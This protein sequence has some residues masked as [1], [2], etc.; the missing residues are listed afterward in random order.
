MR[1][2][3][4]PRS[5]AVACVALM[6]LLPAAHSL[7]LNETPSSNYAVILQ[8]FKFQS[9]FYDD[10]AHAD[11]ALVH[12]GYSVERL[13]DTS[14]DAYAT[15]RLSDFLQTLASGPG[16]VAFSTHGN[17]GGIVVE[18]YGINYTSQMI[19]AYNAY[20]QSG[21]TPAEIEYAIDSEDGYCGIFL[22]ALGIQNH[23][24]GAQSIIYG[25][26]CVSM[27]LA[28]MWT[29][30][31][32][33]VGYPNTCS[34]LQ[35][36]SDFARFWSRLDGAEG[37]AKRAAG[38]ALASTSLAM[39]GNGATVLAPVVLA[40]SP[41]PQATVAC[42]DTGYVVFDTRMDTSADP[43]LAV[44]GVRHLRLDETT[45]IGGDMLRFILR[46]FE[47]DTVIARA[48]APGLRSGAC[49]AIHLDGNQTPSG[50]DGQGPA[51]DSFEWSALSTCD[52]PY[53][54]AWIDGVA[55]RN[56]AARWEAVSEEG[57]EAYRLAGAAGLTSD[58]W[59]PASEEIPAAGSGSVYT[60][61][62]TRAFP[63]YRIEEREARGA[64]RRWLAYPPFAAREAPSREPAPRPARGARPVRIIVPPRLADAAEAHRAA[65]ERLGLSTTVEVTE[66]SPH[67][68]L[69]RVEEGEAGG[70]RGDDGAA[71]RV[72]GASIS[73]GPST[74]VAP[75]AN[76]LAILYPAGLN[77]TGA[78]SAYAA[79]KAA[80]GWDV[81]TVSWPGTPALAAVVAA[82]DSL[83]AAG[84]DAILILG[85][86]RDGNGPGTTMPA[87]MEP[88][89]FTT[90]RDFSPRSET[91][92][93]L[94]DYEKDATDPSRVGPWVGYVPLESTSD[95]WSFAD[96]MA[97]YE[98][99]GPLR[100]NWDNYAAWG[101][102]IQNGWNP[103]QQVVA[104]IDSASA[105]VPAG[106]EKSFLWGSETQGE[107]TIAATASLN[108]G[109]GVVLALS[110]ASAADNPAHWLNGGSGLFDPWT[111]L[112]ANFKYPLFLA[113]S[114]LAGQIDAVDPEDLPVV[115]RD[116]IAV[117][118]RGIIALIGP[119]RGFY[120]DY[121]ARYARRFWEVYATGRHFFLG[122]IH[123]EVRNSLIA[124]SPTDPMTALF[125]RLTILVGDP[126]TTLP[127]V[128]MAGI[129][130][131]DESVAG[132]SALS[133]VWL[134]DPSP[135]PF[136]PRVE[137]RFGL[138]ARM[139]AGLRVIDV[140]GRTVATLVSGELPAG[141]HRATWHG[142]D[143][144]GRPVGSGVY[145]FELRAGGRRLVRRGALV[146]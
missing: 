106:W 83:E 112:T 3:V 84:A 53:P 78:V 114:C 23:F 92:L 97:D 60:L 140:S 47:R 18:T 95:A 127:G 108:A 68:A 5:L 133:G 120:E 43:D 109:Q 125:C 24:V 48:N 116:L 134:T 16:V 77:A 40:V 132:E 35:T 46:P 62:P 138:P 21:L 67:A 117:P 59:A 115:A 42:G 7:A 51:G 71:L 121:Y 14:L 49:S 146:R 4:P 26:S 69:A 85:M 142:R 113:L 28:T 63:V 8:P 101:W 103:P 61:R 29:G 55:W 30:A 143:R 98:W 11:S 37:K 129:T 66:E 86:V 110:T 33:V 88:D 6:T 128:Y 80:L 118:D 57:S 73:P 81:G 20:I 75:A 131:V 96:K 12:Q 58:E 22:T 38:G 124:E 54:V 1:P 2:P 13:F 122:D 139:A 130:S 32:C 17:S 36:E 76:D 99:N 144:D 119:T 74:N 107:W 136:N 141:E 89:S 93:T 123:R 126:T 44:Y 137:I 64:E 70:A 50:S 100:S 145:L 102:D 65:R 135:N 10:A 56:G 87:T 9:G 104:H 79:D 15:S 41:A 27:G 111:D 91:I 52:G 39:A 34:W 72:W 90:F 94:W 25:A 82:I 105:L 19:A 45:W 31:R